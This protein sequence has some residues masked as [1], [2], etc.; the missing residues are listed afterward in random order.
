MDGGRG[1]TPEQV[2]VLTIDQVLMLLT[3]RKLLCNRSKTLS[4]LE[5]VNAV[6]TEDGYICARDVKGN[7]IRGRVR[8]K[9]K[10]RE[11]MEAEAKKKGEEN[12]KLR[13]SRRRGR[14]C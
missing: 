14:V 3:D 6:S 10:A 12:R 9:S 7:L 1:Y 8:G 13:R 2:G 5:A 4:S 11:L